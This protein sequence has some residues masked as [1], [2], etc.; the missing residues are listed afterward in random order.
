MEVIYQKENQDI[1]IRA[2]Y[3]PP[4]AGPDKMHGF[5]H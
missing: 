3:F 4:L 2:V 5:L 1:R